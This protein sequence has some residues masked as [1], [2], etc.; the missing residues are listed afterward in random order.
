MLTTGQK[1]FVS[2]TVVFFLTFFLFFLLFVQFPPT[3]LILTNRHKKF[4]YK[5]IFSKVVFFWISA[6]R[7]DGHYRAGK[8]LVKTSFVLQRNNFSICAPKIDSH[9]Q[10]ENVCSTNCF[11]CFCSFPPIKWIS[12][13]GI[14]CFFNKNLFSAKFFF[15]ISTPKT[16]AHYQADNFESK[17]VFFCCCFFFLISSQKIDPRQ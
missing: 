14:K 15:F 7:M 4:F 13:I 5:K 11:F 16:G 3:K 6:P 17:T 9:Y 1:M 10:A 12:P 2:Q 8:D